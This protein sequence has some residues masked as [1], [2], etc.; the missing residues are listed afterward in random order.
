MYHEQVPKDET[1]NPDR[2]TRHGL[3]SQVGP[4]GVEARRLPHN[5]RPGHEPAR[6]FTIYFEARAQA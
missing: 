1:T 6:A 2:A 5:A 3:Q 4:P